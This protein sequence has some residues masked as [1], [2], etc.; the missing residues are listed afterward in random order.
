MFIKKKK[1]F[2]KNILIFLILIYIISAISFSLVLTRPK[3]LS[4]YDGTAVRNTAASQLGNTGGEK[5]WRWFGANERIEWCAC[6][7]SWCVH[8]HYDNIPKFSSCAKAADWLKEQR[9]FYN[10]NTVP[11]PGM[12][13]FFDWDNDNKPDHTGI[14]DYISANYLHTIEGN[15]NDRCV[16]SKY[17]LK[18]DLIYGYGAVF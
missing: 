11:K 2:L 17:S 4:S 1:N 13:V 8:T 12:I 7:V 15:N 3:P 9:L 16:K 10:R 5:F 18:S 6:F 14:A